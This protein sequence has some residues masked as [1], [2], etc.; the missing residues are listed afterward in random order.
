[1]SPSSR[2]EAAMLG[3]GGIYIESE[4]RRLEEMDQS[5]WRNER[6]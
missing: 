6:K 3:T 5:D 4:Y 1:L 2:A